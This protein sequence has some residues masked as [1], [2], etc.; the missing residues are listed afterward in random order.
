M[1]IGK[2]EKAAFN[3][4]IKDLRREVD[5]IKKKVNEL[6][7]KKKRKK[8]LEPYYNIEAVVFL[9]RSVGINLKMSNVSLKMLGYRN[10][11][12]LDNAK[13]DY[14]KILQLMGEIVGSDVDRTLKE[15]DQYLEKIDR[16]NPAQMLTLI[17]DL[18]HTFHN[19]KSAFG[20]DTK[21]KWLFVEMQA[22]AAIV[23]KNATSFSDIAKLRD[24]RT[25]FFKERK[26]LMDLCK[27][28]LA[29]AAKQYRTKYELSGKA[30]EDLQRTIELLSALRKIHIL[31]GEENEA[32]K[33]KTTIDANR[34]TLEAGDK[35]KDKEKKK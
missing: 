21:W 17:Q 23:T 15:N 19:L 26:E 29:D 2:A 22:K 9:M 6:A 20:E 5:D 33:L 4:E 13:S 32:N 10:T 24:P 28:S 8:N 35:S 12:F 11:K 27:Q 31:F 1:A 18:H 16:I 34:Q 14:S 25:E 30:R 7:V 3:D